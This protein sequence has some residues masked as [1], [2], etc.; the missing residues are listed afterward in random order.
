MQQL[1]P[2]LQ[3]VDVDVFFTYYALPLIGGCIKRWCCLTSVCL[4]ICR[5]HRA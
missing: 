3:P 2:C 5:V 4:S 1:T